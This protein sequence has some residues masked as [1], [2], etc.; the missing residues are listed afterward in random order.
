MT[1]IGVAEMSNELKSK[2]QYRVKSKEYGTFYV[3]CSTH[4]LARLKERKINLLEVLSSLSTHSSDLFKSSLNEEIAFLDNDFDF[5][6]ILSISQT[7][8]N[9]YYVNMITALDGVAKT[10]CGKPRFDQ[11]TEVLEVSYN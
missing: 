10:V 8:N 4:F 6:L 11:Q 5:S 7:E 1:T 2:K 3:S 9:I